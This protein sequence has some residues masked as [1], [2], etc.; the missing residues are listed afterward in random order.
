MAHPFTHGEK[1][2]KNVSFNAYEGEIL[3]VAGLVGS[4][5]SE[6][7]TGLFG[8][9]SKDTSGEIR[10]NG[11]RV[12]IRS[13]K[14]AIKNGMSLV[15]EDRQMLGLVLGQS[16]L[17]NMTLSSL[18]ELSY[19]MGVINKRKERSVVGSFVKKLSIKTPSLEVN[20]ENLSGGNQQKVVLGKW[21]NTNPRILILDEPTRG[22]DVGAKTEIYRIMNNLVK[23][24]CCS[25]NDIIRSL[26]NYG[27]E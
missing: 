24:R 6:L 8:A 14:D 12:N 19:S 17:S 27:Y 10:I 2:V 16:M 26:R 7:V 5:R 13:P 21:L 22:I 9:L 20:V 1:I 18:R 4:G 15:T 25:N 11:K 23:T 3:G